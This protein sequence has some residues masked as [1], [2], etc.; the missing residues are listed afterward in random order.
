MAAA[1]RAGHAAAPRYGRAGA[2]TFERAAGTL[3]PT[4]RGRQSP[5]GVPDDAGPV[6]SRAEAAGRA[7]LAKT[8]DCDDAQ[9]SF[10]SPQSRFEPRR[11]RRRPIRADLA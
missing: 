9:E 3:P 11:M 5:G 4:C 1:E 6:L 8:A 10:A 2:R 7:I